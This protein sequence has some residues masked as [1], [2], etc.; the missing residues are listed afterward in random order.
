M[1]ILAKPQRVPRSSLPAYGVAVP[2]FR[3]AQPP[4]L[5]LARL[6]KDSTIRCAGDKTKTELVRLTET[7]TCIITVKDATKGST[8]AHP[9]DFNTPTV[10]GATYIVANGIKEVS[11]Q[12]SGR[13][14]KFS[15]NKFDAVGNKAG[16]EV[17]VMGKIGAV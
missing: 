5:W 17:V 4:S 12:L 3:K 8:T 13:E 2:N 16:G 9:G 15:L 14:M 6:T 10:S 1:V 7:A 11:N